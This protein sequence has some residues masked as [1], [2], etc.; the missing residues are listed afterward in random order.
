MSAPVLVVTSVDDVTACMVIRALN[1][2]GVP[3]VRVD[4]ADIGNGL[5]FAARLGSG[6]GPAG[7][8]ATLSRE[9]N[10]GAVRSVYHRRP[11][12]WRF[13]HLPEQAR[14][15]ATAEA[16]HGLG[17]LLAG[18]PVLHVNDV[19]ATA[20]AEYKPLQLQAAAGLG[21]A[22][23]PTLIT[24]DPAAVARFEAE[25]GPLVYKTFRGVPSVD[26]KAGAIWTQPVSAAEVDGS[27]AV[28]AHLFQAEVRDKVADARVT[29]VG[30]AVFAWRI[31]APA[32]R[33]LDWRAGSWAELDYAPLTL[34]D[35]LVGR[36]RAYL[37]GF[38]LV[39]GCFDL[40]LTSQ[41]QTVWIECNPNGQWGFLPES[42]RIADAFADL[43]QAG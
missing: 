12:A 7:R 32:G 24:N 18:L 4:P 17:G 21:L 31:T 27:L 19:F 10:L 43:L 36:L 28:T 1:T 3:V 25:H 14:L 39:F 2:R 26:G 15:F 5:T 20:R 13:D 35:D 34:A 29:I 8:L 37:R 9:L 38:G 30:D 6:P 42:E 16:R 11:G 23:P 22:V 33:G 40:A 41:G